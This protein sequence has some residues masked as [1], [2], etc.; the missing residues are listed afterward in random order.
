[1][2]SDLPDQRVEGIL[3]SLEVQPHTN[4]KVTEQSG[5]L[6]QPRVELVNF[7]M[8]VLISINTLD[9]E[10][11]ITEEGLLFELQTTGQMV[12]ISVWLHNTRQRDRDGAIWQKTHR[13][14]SNIV[15]LI[16]GQGNLVMIHSLWDNR[17]LLARVVP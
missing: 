17:M 2:L 11:A 6:Q 3:H 1:M 16:R 12:R 9:Q 4:R 13:G 7:T 5:S 14:L 8:A 10:I 15:V